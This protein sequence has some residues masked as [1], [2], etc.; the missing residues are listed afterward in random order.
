MVVKLGIIGLK[1]KTNGHPYSFSAIINGYNEK[2]FQKSNYK[3]ILNYLKL[4][5]KKDF[6]INKVK[7]TH[8]WT[9][10]NKITKNLC[11]SCNIQ[12]ELTD[13]RKM[14][15]KVDGV[16]I[17]RDDLHFEIAKYFIKKKIPVFVDK[18]LT[19][20]IKE[21]KY[22][23]KYL[24]SGLI[25]STSGLRFAKEL[26]E[27]KSQISKLGKII[28]INATVAS[29][30]KNH[31]IHMLEMIDALNF[32]Q[33]NKIFRI[34]SKIDFI[35]YS[36]RG[37]MEINLFCLGKTSNIYSL[38]FFGSKKNLTIDVSDNFVAFKNTLINFVTLVKNKKPVINPTKSINVLNTFIKTLNTKSYA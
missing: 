36:C 28:C 21:L 24:K 15:S 33:V 34:K 17:A 38:Q 20:N 37:G 6:G 5:K 26:L 25:M 12:N 13:Y 10:N 9:Q 16:I 27:V 18:P 14:S 4:K 32:L 23:K 3:N 22:F 19:T 2:N 1:E 11:K 29:S 8:A 35:K 31:G 30:L 7:I